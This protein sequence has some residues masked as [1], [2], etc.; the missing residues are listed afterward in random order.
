M[1]A[2]RGPTCCCGSTGP[3]S[4]YASGPPEPLRPSTTGNASKRTVDPSGAISVTVPWAIWRRIVWAT[5]HH[6]QTV[7]VTDSIPTTPPSTEP[8]AGAVV[9]ATH[10]HPDGSVETDH[11]NGDHVIVNADG[12][13]CIEHPDGQ[14]VV[15][16]PDGRWIEWLRDGDAVHHAADGTATIVRVDGTAEVRSPEGTVTHLDAERRWIR[17]DFPAVGAA[18]TPGPNGGVVLHT[19]H[20]AVL[21][22][23][24]PFTSVS[25]G[26]GLP[27]VW[28]ALL[29]G[30]GGE[31]VE[32]PWPGRPV[33][34]ETEDA[35]YL[36]DA[37]DRCVALPLTPG[38]AARVLEG[39]MAGGVVARLRERTRQE[40]SRGRVTVGGPAAG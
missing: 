35:V 24:P 4:Q 31:P 25:P 33:A 28:P 8:P 36:F 3:R 26:T 7:T 23:Q 11:S 16:H 21:S 12:S 27:E 18:M 22:G 19:A 1:A 2:W 13:R 34:F 20:G 29:E 10:Q 15:V 5:A 30:T 32:A 14:T 37:P 6:C 9:T 39:E 38:P 40:W 17:V